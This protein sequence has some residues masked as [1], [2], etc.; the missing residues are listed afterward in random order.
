M[1]A[2]FF[3]LGCDGSVVQSDEESTL[4]AYLPLPADLGAVR[5]KILE[6]LRELE[7]IFPEVKTGPVTVGRLRNRD[8]SRGWQRFFR[9]LRVTPRLRIVPAWLP[10]PENPHAETILV[11]PGPAFGT[12][13]H[14]T[15]RMC[16]YAME[17]AALS[18]PWSM[19]DVGTGSG[20][21]AIYAA[22]LG[23]GRI[24]AVDN[25]PEALRWAE[26][27]IVLNGLRGRIELSATE[28]RLL[29]QTFTLLFANLTLPTILELHPDFPAL[30]V[31][32]G[33]MV[34]SGLLRDQ[35]RAVRD[36]L[37][38]E[39]FLADKVLHRGEWASVV[40]RRRA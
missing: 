34:L 28:P 9:P 7:Q 5:K 36:G 2:F 18:L 22:K 3:E 11:D 32:G 30:L 37:R 27:N 15:T 21:L 10:P 35:V 4:K 25:D 6:F 24:V 8:W 14:A 17:R 23:A 16:L 12:G 40:A 33:R 1:E 39:G 38:R 29:K 31:P 13:Q 20:I 26:R 19:L